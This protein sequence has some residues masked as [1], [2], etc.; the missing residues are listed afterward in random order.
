MPAFHVSF[1]RSDEEQDDFKMAFGLFDPEG[2]GAITQKDLWNLIMGLGQMPNDKERAALLDEIN[3]L[4]KDELDYTD[5]L[6]V[7]SQLI[8][9]ID[10]EDEILVAFNIFDRKNVGQIDIEDMQLAFK[11][12]GEKLSDNELQD[13][14]DAVIKGGAPKDADPNDPI[15]T[16][17]NY[18]MFQ[19]MLICR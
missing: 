19:K 11:M 7:M 12:L 1:L 9:D 2:H 18:E 6:G 17:I 10:T 16:T 13:M 14:L 15:P 3:A 5:F 4:T 8:K